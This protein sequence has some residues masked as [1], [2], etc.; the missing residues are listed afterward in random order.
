[1]GVE[2]IS[3]KK[4]E[5]VTKKNNEKIIDFNTLKKKVLMGFLWGGVL[6]LIWLF[7][8][9]FF[10]QEAWSVLGWIFLFLLIGFLVM[11]FTKMIKTNVTRMNDIKYNQKTILPVGIFI[12]FFIA[13]EFLR[14]ILSLIDMFKLP[15]ISLY[16]FVSII[17]I[18]LL[19]TKASPMTVKQQV[20]LWFVFILSNLWYGYVLWNLL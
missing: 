14:N 15:V 2:V 17:V 8:K 10:G 3:Y 13:F 1:M 7:T 18:M 5:F 9:I 4:G 11:N 19:Y 20:W 6:G 16:P 12:L